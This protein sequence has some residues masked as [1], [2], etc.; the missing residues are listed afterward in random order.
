MK[1]Y[2]YI[3]EKFIGHKYRFWCDCL[4]KMDVRGKVLNYNISKNEIILTVMTADNRQVKV[5]F[6]TPSLQV[7]RLD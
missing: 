4:I 5:A 2:Q 3:A 6:N 7:E 1:I